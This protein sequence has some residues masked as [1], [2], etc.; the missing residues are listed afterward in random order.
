MIDFV[1]IS[2]MTYIFFYIPI[3]LSFT[4][5][6]SAGFYKKER[7]K[8]KTASSQ[9]SIIFKYYIMI[10]VAMIWIKQLKIIFL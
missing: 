2:I 10:N 6:I 4:N 5:S 3:T 9:I 8:K 1:F 7:F